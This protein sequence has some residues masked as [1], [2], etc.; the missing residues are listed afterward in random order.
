MVPKINAKTI[1]QA[2]AKA[3]PDPEL[4]L[5]VR[6]DDF[7]VRVE[8][9]DDP[10]FWVRVERET[11]DSIVVTDYNAGSRPDQEL[12]AGVALALR[13]LRR[14]LDK[15]IFRDMFPLGME[16]PDLPVKMIQATEALKKICLHIAAETGQ[17]VASFNLEPRR[18]K[19]DAIAVFR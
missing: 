3:A 8:R 12:A 7:S 18:G 15:V 16:G 17:E 13:T 5:L 19:L 11:G 9:S 6:E 4:D 1:S 2:A 10:R 14:P